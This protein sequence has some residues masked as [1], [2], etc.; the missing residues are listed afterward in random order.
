MTDQAAPKPQLIAAVISAPHHANIVDQTVSFFGDRNWD[1]ARFEQCSVDGQFFARVEWLH[2]HKWLD[3]ADL[4]SELSVLEER[5]NGKIGFDFI[6]RPQ[7]VAVVVD[8]PCF[9]LLDLLNS[10]GHPELKTRQLAFIASRDVDIEPIANRH[11]IPFFV[12]PKSDEA[13]AEAKL[14]ELIKRRWRCAF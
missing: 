3:S 2:D 13:A 5:I 4:K 9:A 11:G 10:G 12:L 14:L 7:P 8:R 6:D 1:I